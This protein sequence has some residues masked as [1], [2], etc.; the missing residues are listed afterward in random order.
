[1]PEKF[2]INLFDFYFYVYIFVCFI[3]YSFIASNNIAYSYKSSA[4][5]LSNLNSLV[6]LDSIIWCTFLMQIF[7][8]IFNV[9]LGNSKKCITKNKKSIKFIASIFEFLA[10]LQLT[11]AWLSL[12]FFT[13]LGFVKSKSG[14]LFFFLFCCYKLMLALLKWCW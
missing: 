1:M 13:I 9:F 8:A 11:M 2:Q 12:N 4:L 3:L 6:E 14:I 7:D 10:T 5:D